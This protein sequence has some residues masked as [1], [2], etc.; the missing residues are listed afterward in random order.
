VGGLPEYRGS[1][2]VKTFGALDR[3]GYRIEKIVYESL[4]GFYVT[5]NVYVPTRGAG[6]FPAVLLPVGHS[7][8]GKGGSREMAVGLVLK[9]FVAL[10][11]DPVGQGERVQYYDADLRGSKVGGPTDEHSHSNGH[12]V[13]IGDNV[14]RYR[15]WDGMRGIDYLQTRADVDPNRIGCSGCSGGGTLATYI[16]AL[17]DRVKAAAPSCYITSWEA[18]LAGPGPQDAEQSFPNFLAE[19]LTIA[20]FVELAAPKPWL[21]ASTI[22]DFFPLEG[23]RQTYEESRRIYELYKAGDRIAWHVGPGEHGTPKPTREAIYGWFVRWLKDGQGDATEA[24]TAP[25]NADNLLVTNTGQVST[26]LGGETVFSLN[27]RRAADLI[28][29]KRNTDRASLISDIRSLTAL[30]LQPGGPAPAL[31]SHRKLRRDGYYLELVSLA[32][33]PGLDAPGLLLRPDGAGPWPAVVVADV[34]SKEIMAAPGGDLEQLVKAGHL[35]LAIQ[36]RGLAEAPQ[37]ARATSILGDSQLAMRAMVVG[38]NIVGM[39]AEDIIRAVDFLAAQPDVDKRRIAAMGY[40]LAGPPVLHAAVIDERIR[41][42]VL[43][44]SLA[45]YRT[46]VD[47]PIH[48]GL[49]DVAIPGVLRK[50]DVAELLTALKPREVVLI[51]PV[52]ALG[53]PEA[54]AGFRSLQR[55]RRDSLLQFLAAP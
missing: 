48:R 1:L 41:R 54:V 8:N 9:G 42:I 53:R 19:G 35:V 30:T 37:A 49:Y 34:R 2:N 17:D 33:E 25:E 39:R 31:V 7:V 55:G 23:A 32:V 45:S 28:P 24:V 4:P 20:D 3:E 51:N 16:S 36:L 52:D 18:L 15:I 43:Q 21:I 22:E 13:L 26:S 27:K 14:A 10:A 5:A 11:Y 46:A 44:D 38:K 6:P 47:R 29:P 12:T 40:G 50:Y